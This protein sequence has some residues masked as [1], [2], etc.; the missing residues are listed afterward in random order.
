MSQTETRTGEAGERDK[1]VMK[2]PSAMIEECGVWLMKRDA[3]FWSLRAA[4]IVAIG[5]FVF[6]SNGRMY[7]GRIWVLA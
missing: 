3:V 1:N 2:D 4:F 7:A 5:F 6:S